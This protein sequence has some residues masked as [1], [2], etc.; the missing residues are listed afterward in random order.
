MLL[1]L[2][3]LAGNWQRSDRSDD[4][5][6]EILSSVILP[7]TP[8]LMP[9][10]SVLITDDDSETFTTWYRQKVR[11]DRADVLN[12]AGNFV[13]MPWYKSFFTPDQIRDYQIRL[14]AG[15]AHSPGEYAGQLRNGIIDTNV[16]RRPIFTS[17]NDL[18]VLAALQETY[19]IEPVDAVGI[20][21]RSLFDTETTTVLY[22]IRVK[23]QAQ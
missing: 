10:N 5:S 6:A 22:R 14:A 16:A 8:E 3:V 12:F 15:V 19:L 9:L 21:N 18:D 17:I 1:P 13:Y 7:E 23:D 4:I 11:G 2:V 20:T